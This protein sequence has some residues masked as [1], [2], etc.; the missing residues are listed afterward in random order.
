M[1]ESKPSDVVPVLLTPGYVI[2]PKGT[3]EKWFP[4]LVAMNEG[5]PIPMTARSISVCEEVIGSLNE[6]IAKVANA[7][8]RATMSAETMNDK[9]KQLAALV[10]VQS[11]EANQVRALASQ[12]DIEG[13]DTL[14][15]PT[16]CERLADLAPVLVHSDD[17]CT[18]YA[19]P[20]PER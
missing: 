18:C 13:W 5:K 10:W 17:V 1:T 14:P 9:A 15:I 6:I 2:P 19:F 4:M 7:F 3:P 16:L 20:A 8:E 11:L 12:Y